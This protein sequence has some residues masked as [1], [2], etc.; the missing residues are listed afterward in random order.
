MDRYDGTDEQGAYRRK[1]RDH[2]LSEQA[3]MLF[4]P[5]L[6]SAD[7]SF[8]KAPLERLSLGADF[9]ACAGERVNERSS[10]GL[11]VVLLTPYKQFSSHVSN[12]GVRICVCCSSECRAIEKRFVSK[13]LGRKVQLIISSNALIYDRIK[14]DCFCLLTALG[15]YTN[16][17]KRC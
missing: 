12:M 1:R 14:T 7:S 6:I 16:R 9:G 3:T 8:P 5:A 11:I 2:G 15:Y 17:G 4:A 13:Y 10:E